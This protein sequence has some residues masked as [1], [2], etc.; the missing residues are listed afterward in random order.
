LALELP[1]RHPVIDEMGIIVAAIGGM[2][3]G[4]ERQWSGHATGPRARFAGIRT[5]FLLGGIAGA[6]GWLHAG[7]ATILAGALLAAV[8]AL[9]IV[10]YASVSRS[11]IDATTEVSALVV[12]AAGVLAGL[13]QLRLAS[14]AIALTCFVLVE[15]SRLHALVKRIDDESLHAAARFAVM[16]VVVL[17]LLPQGP[18]G[19]WDAIRPRELWLLVLFCSGLSFGG[20]IARR[21]LGGTHGYAL[22]GLFGGLISSTNVALTFAHTSRHTR[23]VGASLADGVIAACTV[24]FVRVL[25]LTVV[26]EP[27]LARVLLPYTLAPLLVG[28]A[29]LTVRVRSRT[30]RV[31]E[32]EPARNPLQ[33]GA[34][35]QMAAVFQIVLLGV[36]WAR[37]VWGEAGVIASGAVLGLTDVDALTI[38]MAKGVTGGVPVEVAARALAIGILAN[39]GLK[40]AIVLSIGASAFRRAAAL[41]LAAMTLALAGTLLVWR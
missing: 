14:G 17:P 39:T 7:G 27:G 16:A 15:K 11:E 20:F 19:P 26:L 8:V 31:S 29:V 4:V 21:A 32:A 18:Y 24:L 3:V 12:V 22:A 9:V 30:G 1:R 36:E 41:A 34:A 13:G 28:V 40:L 38:S 6:I 23:Q 33:I 25:V 37:R 35:L 5:F 10:A 2:A